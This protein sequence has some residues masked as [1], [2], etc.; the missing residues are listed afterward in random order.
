MAVAGGIV[1]EPAVPAILLPHP[2]RTHLGRSIGALGA[3]MA[4]ELPRVVTKD[5]R[6]ALFVDGAPYLILGG[7]AHNS[8][9][10]PSQL[11]K[12]WPVMKALSANTI[13]VP[14]AW[15]QFEPK[16]G[17]FDYSWVNTLPAG[18]ASRFLH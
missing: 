7:Q 8:S 4:A 14:V 3:A 17:R 5:G 11:P 18:K 15:E 10:Y 1:E 12:V 16:E 2:I 9:N 13:E 6:H